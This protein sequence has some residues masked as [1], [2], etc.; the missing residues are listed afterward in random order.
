MKIQVLKVI[1]R[2]IG[3]G[4]AVLLISATGENAMR[5]RLLATLLLVV[6]LLIGRLAAYFQRKENEQQPIVAVEASVVSHRTIREEVGR[7]TVI[8]YYITFRPVDG[9]MSVELEVSELNFEDFD[10]DET[11]TLRYRGWEFLS[12]GLKD[13]SGVKPI[14]PLPEEY[15]PRPEPK[16]RRISL[17]EALMA[18]RTRHAR[19]SVPHKAEAESAP[20]KGPG[21]LTHE[22]DE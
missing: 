12:F 17:K 14:A 13:K 8:R 21:I 19:H 4:T 9:G 1:T 22:L 10:L 16:R 11:G 15:E 5:F 2:V 3:F 18:L 6:L 7:S 20:A